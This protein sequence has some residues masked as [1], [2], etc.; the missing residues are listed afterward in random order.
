[1]KNYLRI[2]RHLTV[3]N[4][5]P[6][7][8]KFWVAKAASVKSK[9]FS[10]SDIQSSYEKSNGRENSAECIMVEWFP[11]DGAAY[12]VRVFLM[13]GCRDGRNRYIRCIPA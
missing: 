8:G 7:N 6:E 5:I 10:P 2:Q 13:K 3:E 12:P 9:L 4:Y 11:E 1:M